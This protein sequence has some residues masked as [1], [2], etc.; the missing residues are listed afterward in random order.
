MGDMMH[1]E[2]L[3]PRIRA[4][5]E[6]YHRPPNLD[7][8]REAMWTA[9][10][11]ERARRRRRR[12]VVW[13]GLAW[14]AGVAAVLA[15]G[16]AIG[17]WSAVTQPG[18]VV[19]AAADPQVAYRVAATQYL[20]RTEALLIGFRASAGRSQAD[21]QFVRSG[22]ELL[23]MTRLMLD[24]PAADDARL[25]SLLEDLELVLVQITQLAAARTPEERQLIT[26]GIEQRNV[27]AR[28]RT[29]IPAGQVVRPQGAL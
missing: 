9:I 6:D 3:D 25:R 26:Q 23:G 7:L 10:Q 29:E 22:R 15:V 24:S 1:D 5:A 8:P 13:T 12:T 28:L 2:Q 19:V 17:R 14:A 11:A 20:S 21:T 4:A 27:L 18:G 16:V